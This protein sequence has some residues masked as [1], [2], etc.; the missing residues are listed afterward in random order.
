MMFR[1]IRYQCL[2]TGTRRTRSRS[3]L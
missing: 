2:Y 3:Q 1:G